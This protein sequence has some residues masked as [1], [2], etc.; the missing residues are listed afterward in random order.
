MLDVARVGDSGASYMRVLFVFRQSGTSQLLTPV[1]R[2]AAVTRPAN[3]R[4]PPAFRRDSTSVTPFPVPVQ[5]NPRFPVG[6]ERAS[7]IPEGGGPRVFLP[8]EPVAGRHPIVLRSVPDIRQSS[9][10]PS[11]LESLPGYPVS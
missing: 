11:D 1:G 9:I 4:K 2:S 10:E 5:E 3:A 8:D 6:N 7:A